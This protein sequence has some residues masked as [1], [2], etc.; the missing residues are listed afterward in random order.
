MKY[1]LL[2]LAVLLVSA[3]AFAQVN[4]ETKWKIHRTP[5]FDL[6]FDANH[7]EIAKATAE[8]LEEIADTLSKTF[9][10]VPEKTLLVINDYT[11]LTNGY[12]TALPR[13]TIVIFPVLPGPLE[14]IYEHGDW[15][16]ELILHEYTHILS[17]EPRRG[18]MRVLRSVFGNIITPNMLLPRWW[19]E[20]VAVE[21]ETAETS[22]GRLR[23][24][25]QQA[26]LR[27]YEADETLG[28]TT[29][30]QINET[31]IPSWP[32][33]ARPYLFGSL[34][35]SWMVE[36]KKSSVIESLHDSY[37][38]RVP[39]LLDGPAYNFLETSYQGVFQQMM[40]DLQARLQKQLAVIRQIPT[41]VTQPLTTGSVE[42]FSPAI[43]PDGLKMVYL[44]K[45]ETLRR[46]LKILVRPSTQVRFDESQSKSQVTQR[47]TEDSVDASPLP[48]RN[49]DGP[50]TG[51]ISRISWFP[52]SKKFVFDRVT[53]ISRYQEN[54]DLWIFDVEKGKTEPLTKAQ[55]AREPNVSPNGQEIVFVQLGP[56]YTEIA[57]MDLQTKQITTLVPRELLSTYSFPTFW[58]PQEVVFTKRHRSG[59]EQMLKVNVQTLA[60]Q[61]VLSGFDSPR[62]SDNS[63]LGLLFTSS[64]SGVPN[65]Y[66]ADTTLKQARPITHTATAISVSTYDSFRK[67]LYVS[68]L[69]SN[70]YR[71]RILP[72]TEMDRLSKHTLPKVTDLFADRYPITPGGAPP[73]AVTA[74]AGGAPGGVTLSEEDYSPYGYLWPTYWIP[75]LSVSS[76]GSFIGA[77]T[78]GQDPVGLHAY[79]AAAGYD[80]AS[81]ETSYNLVYVNQN[82]KPVISATAEDYRTNIT[83]TGY[84][85]RVQTEGLNALWQLTPWSPDLD[86]LTGWQWK[87]KDF[88]TNK[89]YQTGPRVGFVYGNYSQSGA[90]I[91]PETGWGGQLLHTSYLRDN[92]KT[93]F[94]ETRFSYVQY[95][96]KWLP[97]RH[98]FMAK[99][100]GLFIEDNV[101][102]SNYEST[103]SFPFFANSTTPIY[104]MRGFRSGQFMGKTLANAIFEYRFP[105]TTIYRG[106]GVTPLFFRRF[107]GALVADGIQMDGLAYDETLNTPA[108]NFKTIDKWKSYWDA[109]VEL[110]A[111]ITLG[112]HIPLTFYL[113]VYWPLES[114]VADKTNQFALGIML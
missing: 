90:Q 56:G 28:E 9:S 1:L 71:I 7:Q 64:V 69:T 10:R 76:S 114:P 17:F 24:K 110:K 77:T 51:T 11:D 93:G 30:A 21:R 68:E 99:L 85:Y 50:P 78:S 44:A 52:D 22:N 112:Y 45:D 23:S 83:L 107:H 74:A 19:L 20:G 80:S 97:T 94:N 82:F 58:N 95:F 72:A 59:T 31:S 61:P 87:S 36:Q 6:I 40:F 57:K 5:R 34:M 18:V 70:G 55:R 102:I 41:H 47:L 65:L 8:H 66:V 88:G 89:S 111:D 100:Q 33:G 26:M 29:L 25:A 67:E 4:P 62:F 103:F 2:Q 104:L 43:S 38:G 12:A 113:G 101:G 3:T 48:S 60:M 106:S 84:R 54:S 79:S 13:N 63:P 27:S 98:V 86:L 73:A 92:S 49:P 75:S 81:K 53:E 46:A 96:S 91:S 39:Y 105:I 109:G 14:S 15:S 32:Q 37:A 16:R 108:Y 35:W 42:T